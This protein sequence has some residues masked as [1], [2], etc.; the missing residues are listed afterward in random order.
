MN[1]IRESFDAIY[2]L[3]TKYWTDTWNLMFSNFDTVFGSKL[4][5]KCKYIVLT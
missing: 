1:K 2:L 4:C 5:N 3:N